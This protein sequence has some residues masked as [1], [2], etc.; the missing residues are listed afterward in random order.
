VL[1]LLEPL[2]MVYSVVSDMTHPR[3]INREIDEY[4][5][6]WWLIDTGVPHLVSI[7]DEYR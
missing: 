2:L 1:E 4:G 7:R 5:Y 6:I 3:I